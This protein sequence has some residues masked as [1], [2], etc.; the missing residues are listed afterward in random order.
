LRTTWLLPGYYHGR[1]V[2]QVDRML[3]QYNPH[4]RL[5]RMLSA[6]TM[7]QV[8]GY[9]GPPWLAGLGEDASRIDEQNVGDEVGD[10]HNMQVF[11]A[12]PN[13][14]DEIRHYVLWQ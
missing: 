12:C 8:L 13:V 4:D 11:F 3:V 2:S 1:C 10:A 5:L 9:T 7:T 14:M 6:C